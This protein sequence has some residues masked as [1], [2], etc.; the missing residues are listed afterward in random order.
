MPTG[1]RHAPQIENRR[2]VLAPAT[3]D[4][5]DKKCTYFPGTFSDVTDDAKPVEP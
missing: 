2:K 1:A 5:M 4:D 3:C